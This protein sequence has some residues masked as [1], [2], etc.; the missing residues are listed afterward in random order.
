[1]AD[2][3]R[4]RLALPGAD[5]Q[6]NVGIGVG[7]GTRRRQARLRDDLARFCAMLRTSATWPRRP[8]SGR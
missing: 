5:G 8:R 7:L 4:V 2:L 6:A 3:P 1:M